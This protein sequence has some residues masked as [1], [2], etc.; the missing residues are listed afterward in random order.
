MTGASLAGERMTAVPLRK[1]DRRRN[2]PWD[3]GGIV[4]ADR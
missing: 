3:P 1:A 2:R 4:W